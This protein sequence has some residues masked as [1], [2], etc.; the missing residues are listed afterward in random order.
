MIVFTNGVFDILHV[1]HIRLLRFAKEQGDVLVVG[2]NSDRSTAALKG[3]TRP[4]NN[5]QDRREALLAI[6]YV[7][8]VIIFREQTPHVLIG[9]IDPDIVVKGG[10]YHENDVVAGNRA[11]VVLA[12]FYPSYSTTKY[13]NFISR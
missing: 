2:I 6:K 5:E 11:R 7:D 1:G 13:A 3:P 4:F 8:D 9:C 10:D 12:P